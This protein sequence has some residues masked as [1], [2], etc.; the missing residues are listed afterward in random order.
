S[1]AEARFFELLAEFDREELWRCLGCHSAAHW[2]TWQ[3]GFGD[4]AARERVRV[5]RALE[6]LPEIRAAFR[7][8]ELSYSKVRELTRVARPE[9][10]RALLQLALRGTAEQ[11]QRVVALHR[12][13]ER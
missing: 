3:C 2:L 7:R 1:A 9:T 10:E 4:V 13:A 8:G 11:V 12:R 5:A 6:K